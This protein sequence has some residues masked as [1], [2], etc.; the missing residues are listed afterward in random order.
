MRIRP[1]RIT[2]VPA[3]ALLVVASVLGVPAT[4]AGGSTVPTVATATPSGSAESTGTAWDVPPSASITVL[5]RG[6][7]HGHGMSQYGAEGAARQGLSAREIVSFYYPGTELGHVGG[8]LR[9]LLTADTTD[10]VVV[11][12][13]PGL[14]VRDVAGRTTWRLPDDGA[15]RWRLV[16]RRGG[17]TVIASLTDRWR[18]WRTVAGEAEFAAGGRPIRLVTP[19]G[20]SSYRGR[21]R[22]AAPFEGERARDTVNH[23]SMQAYL[24]GVVPLEIPASW[25]PA[26]VQAQAIAA[27]TY[28]AYERGHARA[29]HYQICDTTQCQ[30]YGGA[31]DEHPA[32][33][34]A[35]RATRGIGVLHH[36]QP[37]FTQFSS[38]S[39]GWTSAG[40]APY[41]AHRADPYDGWSGNPVHEWST[42]VTDVQVER[43]FPQVGDLLRIAVSSREGGGEWGGRVRSMTLTGSQGAVTV[44]GDAFRSALGLKS[45]WFSFRVAAR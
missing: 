23:V 20:T 21:L 15:R 5:G 29:R 12:A 41:L 24:R 3:A 8:R 13:D 11:L 22:S 42:G 40:S 34:A 1:A 14:R 6:F 36:G 4:A 32:S 19:S 7:G 30:V 38:S 35:V 45:S 18:P 25:S 39:G 33:D 37:A 44:T 2:L 16:A 27:R 26:A 31:D 9:V 17:R 10:D 43:A 28:A